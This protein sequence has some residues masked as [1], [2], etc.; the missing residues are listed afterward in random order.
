[1]SSLT[2]F[3]TCSSAW[4][5]KILVP[6]A[7]GSPGSG[8]SRDSS[9]IERNLQPLAECAVTEAHGLVFNAIKVG[10]RPLPSVGPDL[11]RF[12]IFGICPRAV[13]FEACGK[14][15]CE[16]SAP[17]GNVFFRDPVDFGFVRMPYYVVFEGNNAAYVSAGNL[18]GIQ[19]AVAV[20]VLL[21]WSREHEFL[22]LDFEF[23]TLAIN[24]PRVEVVRFF[25]R[26]DV[27]GK[28]SFVASFGTENP[29]NTALVA[30]I[31]L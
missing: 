19:V 30:N 11:L 26:T 14:F 1:M 5:G 8:A 24:A 15:E 13:V 12:E 29:Y 10:E 2:D 31:L 21:V 20:K 3:W 6:G 23:V 22:G 18:C 17:D 7:D 16:R 25:L 4:V 28:G 9:A 27:H